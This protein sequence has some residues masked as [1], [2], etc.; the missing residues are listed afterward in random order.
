[1][2]EPKPASMAEMV[3]DLSKGLA[4]YGAFD[5]PYVL[6]GHSLGAW[7]AYTCEPTR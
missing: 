5:L 6:L 1:M 2:L 3:A 7:C 4:D